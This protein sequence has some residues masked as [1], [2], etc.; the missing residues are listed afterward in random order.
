MESGEKSDNSREDRP[1]LAFLVL[2]TVVGWGW[3]GRRAR[4][5][6]LQG[7]G[8]PGHY[9]SSTDGMLS[10]GLGTGR[11]IGEVPGDTLSQD[12]TDKNTGVLPSLQVGHG[13]VHHR[14]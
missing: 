4:R 7:R 14:N 2:L 8:G 1:C 10:A 12:Q 6:C 3:R 5:D 13:T 11:D 9:S